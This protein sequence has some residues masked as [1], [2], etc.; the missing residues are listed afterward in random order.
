MSRSLSA[1]CCRF[2]AFLGAS[3]LSAGVSF[4]AAAGIGMANYRPIVWEIEGTGIEVTGSGSAINRVL[5]TCPFEMMSGSTKD[6]IYAAAADA[7]KKKGDP[8]G[9]PFAT[10]RNGVSNEKLYLSIC[11]NFYRSMNLALPVTLG[12]PRPTTYIGC[13]LEPTLRAQ[14]VLNQTIENEKGRVDKAN[15]LAGAA[16]L[17]LESSIEARKAEEK[18][19]KEEEEAKKQCKQA[20]KK[21]ISDFWAKKKEVQCYKAVRK[22]IKD[23]SKEKVKEI[24]AQVKQL[25]AT[26]VSAR[27]SVFGTSVPSPIGIALAAASVADSAAD[28]VGTALDL[29]EMLK[30]MN[31]GCAGVITGL[32]ALQDFQTQ[33][34]DQL[35][36]QGL[37]SLIER[38]M[39]QCIRV[40]F[41]ADLRLPRF[42]LA[43]QCPV[44]LNVN[45]TYAAGRFN[46]SASGSVSTGVNATLG[47]QSLLSTTDGSLSKAFSSDCFTSSE[48]QKALNGGVAGADLGGLP[49][50]SGGRIPGSDCNTLDSNPAKNEPIKG[51]K[52]L[53]ANFTRTGWAVGGSETLAGSGLTITRCDYYDNGDRMKTN[54]VFGSGTSCNTGANGFMDSGFEANTACYPNGGYTPASLPSVPDACLY[55]P[56]CLDAG[57][58]FSSTREGTGNCPKPANPAFDETRTYA[59]VSGGGIGPQET[60]VLS[61]KDFAT[62]LEPEVQCCDPQVQNCTT[63]DVNVKLCSC[64]S[65]NALNKIKLVPNVNDP[66]GTTMIQD[67]AGYCEQGGKVTCCSKNLN[68]KD[69]CM[70]NMGLGSICANEA[71]KESQCV[72]KD[73][74][75]TYIGPK[76]TEKTITAKDLVLSKPSPYVYLFIRPDAK[77]GNEQC[78]MTKWCN[79]C[80]QHYANAYGLS[81]VQSDR[82]Q[83]ESDAENNALLGVGWPFIDEYNLQGVQMNKY[84]IGINP[85][86]LVSKITYRGSDGWYKEYVST[87][88]PSMAMASDM[89]DKPLYAALN[90]CNAISPWKAHWVKEDD[91]NN[92]EMGFRIDYFLD[93]PLPGKQQDEIN[94]KKTDDEKNTTNISVV[95]S[96]PDDGGARIRKYSVAKIPSMREMP[97]DY[98]NRMRAAMSSEDK[99]LAPIPLCSE[100]VKICVPNAN[101]ALTG[102]GTLGTPNGTN[103]G[104]GNTTPATVPA[105]DTPV[106][107][108]PVTN[109]GTSPGGGGGGAERVEALSSKAGAASSI[110]VVPSASATQNGATAVPSATNS[111]SSSSSS[112]KGSLY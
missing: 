78:C 49:S 29:E 93:L 2:I 72:G 75:A 33:V 30:T 112:V 6:K 46:C 3:L 56:D 48:E 86:N 104:G 10:D 106:V 109:P 77:I 84:K 110:M 105:A 60:K 36:C 68:G 66:T 61:C 101:T 7:A 102:G 18:R 87:A 28:L 97:L 53:K 100:V 25:S 23:I 80:P 20:A 38:Q 111:G 71:S 34:L 59:T 32:E 54:Y 69:W 1:F 41:S 88:Y 58:A 98:I 103:N 14:A 26:F 12:Q 64:D 19:R 35:S 74:L 24:K 17:S 67:P 95:V 96:T 43:L 107:V 13:E 8:D 108:T 94:S 44:N 45:M 31:E 79:V 11:R 57:G 5:G 51:E 55:H 42:S 50:S 39:T 83:A 73:T 4:P 16:I 62:V 22:I 82:K 63:R 92:G 81:L 89:A 21:R 15:A 65:G 47:R 52:Y 70:A 27:D 9:C 91:F 85:I 40:N 37:A 99:T 76:G 90:D